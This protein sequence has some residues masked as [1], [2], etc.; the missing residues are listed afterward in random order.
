MSD[1]KKLTPAQMDNLVRVSLE[2]SDIDEVLENLE[3]D[4][5]TKQILFG[6]SDVFNICVTESG[7]YSPRVEGDRVRTFA[8]NQIFKIIKDYFEEKKKLLVEEVEA[9]ISEEGGER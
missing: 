4:E 5:F 8:D 2:M 1:R 3:D 6:R 7:G 9:I